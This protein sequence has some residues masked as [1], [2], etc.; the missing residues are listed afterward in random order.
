MNAADGAI[1][2]KRLL[3]WPS[4]DS[5]MWYRRGYPC[6]PSTAVG[7][8]CK[9]PCWFER[10]EKLVWLEESGEGEGIEETE[11]VDEMERGS[12]KRHDWQAKDGQWLPISPSAKFKSRSLGRQK[13]HG[14]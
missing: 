12:T 10:L 1:P 7:A 2:V 3:A 14:S 6:H 11:E 8:E 9:I 5:W 13:S 4:S